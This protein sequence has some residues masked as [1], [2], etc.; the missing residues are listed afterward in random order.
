MGARRGA[1]RSA[2]TSLAMASADASS[3]NSYE[4]MDEDQELD[5]AYAMVDESAYVH[6]T[7]PDSRT[8][9]TTL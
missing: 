6:T 2:P 7:H 5:Q 1:T 4:R 3:A 9:R 8:T